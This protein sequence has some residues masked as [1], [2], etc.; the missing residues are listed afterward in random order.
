[1]WRPLF[2]GATERPRSGR[3]TCT[4]PENPLI[5]GLP[6]ACT[7][8]AE[9]LHTAVAGSCL[10]ERVTGTTRSMSESRDVVESTMR[11]FR[12]ELSAILEQLDEDVPRDDR[13][14]LLTGLSRSLASVRTVFDRRAPRPTD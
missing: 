11:E 1:M 12:R 6:R 5:G 4:E 13:K 3:K 14:T 2:V 8:D 7:D 9:G 10:T